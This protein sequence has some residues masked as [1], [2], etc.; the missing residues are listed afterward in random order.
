MRLVV[1]LVSEQLVN[2]I[3]KGD[4]AIPGQVVKSTF[5][6]RNVC[7]LDNAAAKP[8]NFVTS[9]P[10]GKIGKLL[11]KSIKTAKKN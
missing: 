6:H 1:V 11:S 7:H 8:S 5:F 4:A 10:S 3:C 9:P 2:K